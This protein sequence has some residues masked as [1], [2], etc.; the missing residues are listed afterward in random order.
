MTYPFAAAKELKQDGIVLRYL[1]LLDVD[2]MLPQ[3]LLEQEGGSHAEPIYPKAIIQD[4]VVNYIVREDPPIITPDSE[5]PTEIDV[6]LSV[7]E[8]QRNNIQFSAGYSG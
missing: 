1:N 2:K 5:E 3:G 6:T 7:K 8:L 4:K